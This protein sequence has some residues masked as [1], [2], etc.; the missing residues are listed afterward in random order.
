MN[1]QRKKEREDHDLDTVATTGPETLDLIPSDGH[2]F[3]EVGL[4]FIGR[5]ERCSRRYARSRLG[6]KGGSYLLGYEEERQ[7]F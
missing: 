3:P 4:D 1:S 7:A 2:L 5:S 6:D